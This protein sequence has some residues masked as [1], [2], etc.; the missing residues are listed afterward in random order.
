MEKHN[1]LTGGLNGLIKF[2]DTE[3]HIPH[4]RGK[5]KYKNK[6]GIILFLWVNSQMVDTIN[7]NEIWQTNASNSNLYRT[8]GPHVHTATST[9]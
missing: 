4:I 6:L 3:K 2:A 5:L 8:N 7:V 9:P 1:F